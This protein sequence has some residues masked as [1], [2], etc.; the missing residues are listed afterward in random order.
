MG[1]ASA[2]MLFDL[3]AGKAETPTEMLIRG[4][5]IVRESCGAV[6]R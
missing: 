6:C 2:R 3:L 5:L 4:R 1:Q